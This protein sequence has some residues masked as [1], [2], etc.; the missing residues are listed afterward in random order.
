MAKV[1]LKQL[2]KGQQQRT[3]LLKRVIQTSGSPAKFDSVFSWL[4]INRYIMKSGSRHREPYKITSRG[5]KF[6]AVL[7]S[8]EENSR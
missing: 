1:I 4:K 7:D 2:E 5:R 8:E 6:L 3:S